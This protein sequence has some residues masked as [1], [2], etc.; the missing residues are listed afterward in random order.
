MAFLI[1]QKQPPWLFLFYYSVACELNVTLFASKNEIECCLLTM[2]IISDIFFI[3]I[4]YG[5]SLWIQ[6]RK[7]IAVQNALAANDAQLEMRLP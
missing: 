6:S 3:S 1:K 4:W 2:I 7:Q 5:G